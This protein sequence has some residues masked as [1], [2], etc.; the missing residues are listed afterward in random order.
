M[1]DHPA[2]LMTGE[3]VGVQALNLLRQA[4]WQMGRTPTHRTRIERLEETSDDPA[5]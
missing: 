2:Q 1:A 5:E 4:L 3:E